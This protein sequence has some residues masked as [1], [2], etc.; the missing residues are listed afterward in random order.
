MAGH[1]AA[2]G[3]QWLYGVLSGDTTLLSY[4]TGGVHRAMA[5]PGTSPVYV[6]I[7]H[8]SG[9][10]VLTVNAF[11]LMDNLLY[12]AKAVGPAS[13]MDTIV[14]AAERI[15]QL[16]SPNQGASSGTVTGGYIGNCHREQPIFLDEPGLINGELWTNVGGL[17]RLEI[18]QT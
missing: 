9:L 7:S 4:A 3:I 18:K 15:D 16:L 14:A 17:Y 5:P 1:E 11:R 12:Q 6:I 10:D 2:L 13:M 8:Q